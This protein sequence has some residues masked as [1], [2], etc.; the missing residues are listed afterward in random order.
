V[1]DAPPAF[2]LLERAPLDWHPAAA[3]SAITGEPVTPAFLDGITVR[4]V[5]VARE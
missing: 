1:D 5:V 4:G 2:D 3:A